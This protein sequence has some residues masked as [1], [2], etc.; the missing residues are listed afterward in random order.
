MRESVSRPGSRGHSHSHTAGSQVQEPPGQPL[1]EGG[2]WVQWVQLL[3]KAAAG[4]GEHLEDVRKCGGLADSGLLMACMEP[5]LWGPRLCTA[6]LARCLSTAWEVRSSTPHPHHHP[7][8]S[9]WPLSS[10]HPSPP[11]LG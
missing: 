11:T 10:H 2:S 6:D 9:D 1:V 7:L 8:S 3:W 5:V 4:R